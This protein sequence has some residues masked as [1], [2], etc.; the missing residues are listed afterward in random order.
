MNIWFLAAI[1][2]TIG[3][4]ICG[5]VIVRAPLMDRLIALELVGILS[6]LIFMLL[7]QGLGQEIFYDMALT[8]AVLSLPGTL[9]FVHF[10]E[11]WL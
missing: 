2:L 10:L 4:A 1:A 8:L 6:T 3:L 5:I 11:R 9:V 7:A